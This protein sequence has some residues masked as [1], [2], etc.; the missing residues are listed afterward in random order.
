MQ[1]YEPLDISRSCNSGPEILGSGAADV[2]TGLK[3]FRGLPFMIGGLASGLGGNSFIAPSPNGGSVSV[4][5][6]KPAKRVLFAHALLETKLA[7]G[8]RLGEPVAEYVFYLSSGRQERVN[9]RER[10]EIAAS[11]AFPPGTPGP[12]YRAVTDSKAVLMPRYEGEFGEAGRRQTEANQPSADLCW[13]W[14]WENPEP[15]SSIE[16]IEIVPAGMRFFVAAITLGHLD[17]HPFPREGRRPAKITLLDE[18]DASKPFDVEVE[19]DRGDATYVF[20]LP[21]VSTDEFLAAPIPGGRTTTR[22]PARPTWRY[23]PRR[24]R[25]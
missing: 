1:D 19:V 22:L 13:L 6:G 16:S 8:G 9:I 20:P 11:P 17:E 7:E 12:P 3:S 10:F 24:P 25:P 15:D 21:A 23:R 5:V 2:E 4:P 14:S 18:A